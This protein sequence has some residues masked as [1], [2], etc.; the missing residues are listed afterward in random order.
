MCTFLDFVFLSDAVFF[1]QEKRK[2]YWKAINIGERATEDD[3]SFVFSL[4]A[5]IIISHSS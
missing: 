2:E 5:V 4:V 1:S 3:L